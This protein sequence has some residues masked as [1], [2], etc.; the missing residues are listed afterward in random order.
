MII[1]IDPESFL[2]TAIP[3]VYGVIHYISVLLDVKF[4]G[5]FS[6]AQDVEFLSAVVGVRK[7]IAPRLCCGSLIL[8]IS[9]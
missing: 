4:I 9:G 5:H 7:F 6:P 2:D 8:I 1:E 3:F